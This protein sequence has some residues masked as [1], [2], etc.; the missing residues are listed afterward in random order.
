MHAVHFAK[1]CYLGQEI[2]ERIRSRGH[3]NR[4]LKKLELDGEAPLPAGT[5]IVTAAGETAEVTSSAYSPALG[6]VVALAYVRAKST[7][8]N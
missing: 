3:V 1:G 8:S 6:E 4:Q 5:K 7:E 2:V